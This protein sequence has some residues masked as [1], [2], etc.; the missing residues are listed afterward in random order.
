MC[1]DLKREFYA[2]CPVW[3]W[4]VLWWQF[5]MM[6]R[7][8][9]RLYAT[10]GRGEMTYGLALSSHGRLRLIF[11]S[12]AARGAVAG[13]YIPAMPAFPKLMQMPINPSTEYPSGEFAIEAT[14]APLYATLTSPQTYFDPG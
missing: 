2:A 7:Y 10:R 8:L 11:V 12:D 13:R 1:D 4:P 3:Y 9:A 6:E 5:V 14:H